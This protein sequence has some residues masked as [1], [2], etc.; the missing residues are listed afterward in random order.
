MDQGIAQQKVKDLTTEIESKIQQVN[1]VVED[2]LFSLEMQEQ[3]NWPDMVQ[4]FCSLSSMFTSLQNLLKK[5]G[6][7][8]E[9]NLKLLKMTQLVPQVVSL[10]PDQTLQELTSGR[11]T[12]FNHNVVPI[13]LRTKLKPEVEEIESNLERERSAKQ[14]DVSKQIKSINAHIDMLCGKL[15]DFTKLHVAD[16]REQP[17]FSN[18]ETM[19]LVRAVCLGKGIQPKPV[20][21]AT[22]APTDSSKTTSTYAKS[23]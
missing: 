22:A 4:K 20:S 2:L 12:S 9:D 11:L 13:M 18:D 19:K 21:A 5:S 23:K 17:S 8:L 3:V 14:V 15:G 10:E 7:D 6:I 16:K 1:N